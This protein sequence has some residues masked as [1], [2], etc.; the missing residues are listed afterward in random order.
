MWQN[1]P[2][3]PPRASALAWQVDGLY[4]LLVAVSAFF[5][6]LI[7]LLIFIFGIKYPPLRSSSSGAD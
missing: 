6:L 7:F 5:T 2:L 4:F 3:F 1:F